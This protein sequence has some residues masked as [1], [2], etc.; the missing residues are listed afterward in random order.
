MCANAFGVHPRAGVSISTRRWFGQTRA[1]TRFYWFLKPI[2]T[3]K[4]EWH[5]KC[6]ALEI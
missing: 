6:F 3:N 1:I 2:R 5:T 4:E